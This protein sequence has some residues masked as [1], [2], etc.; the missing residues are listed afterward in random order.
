MPAVHV[1]KSSNGL[2]TSI[3]GDTK[4]YSA[5]QADDESRFSIF[6][7]LVPIVAD[8]TVTYLN[9]SFAPPS[10]LV[11]HDAI[12]QYSSEALRHPSPK[13]RWQEAVEET[14][15]LVAKY[16]NADSSA[17]AFTRDTTEALGSFI[18]GIRFQPGDNVVI[19]DTE[20]PN[21]AYAWM[22][23]RQA[24]LEVRQVPTIAE[25]ERT[26]K[27]VAANAATFAPYVDRRTR[28]IGLSSVMFHSGQWNDIADICTA[29]RPKG[30][31]I[32][33]DVTQQV[34][35]ARI[36]VRSLGVS[37]AAF[38]LHKG[39]NCP[40]G[41]AVLYVDT[42]VI[43]EMD[44]IPPIVGYGAVSNARSD[45]LV[46]ADPIVYHPT[47]R[48]YEHL[49]LSLIAVA[50]AKAFLKFYLEVMGPEAVERHLYALGDALYQECKGLGIG[51]V[52]PKNRKEHAPHLYILDLHNT[53]WVEHLKDAGIIV[54]PYRLGIRVSFGFYNNFEDVKKLS[55]AVRA[56]LDAGIPTTGRNM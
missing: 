13:P 38:S 10:N 20:H 47:A 40:T 26:G 11:V 29:Y 36:D 3:N 49:N 32:V 22:S 7:R 23:L 1:E 14:R 19:L 6:R 54:T 51:I 56:G 8:D 50:A 45:L 12:C 55:L 37:A 46:P 16:I 15:E 48:R 25:A 2:A 34:G 21:H 5:L 4:E 41:L 33:A 27:V 43:C 53:G 9:A 30:I 44:P 39:L 31:H 35:F 24:G 52:G 28:A 17:I 18:Q 42:D